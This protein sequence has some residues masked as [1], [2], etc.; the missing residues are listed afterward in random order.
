MILLKLKSFFDGH[1]MGSC[2]QYH[3]MQAAKSEFT[4]DHSVA[5]SVNHRKAKLA[6][7]MA[8]AAR[9]QKTQA[10][11]MKKQHAA[12]LNV[13]IGSIVCLKVDIRDRSRCNSTG[14]IAVAFNVS[15]N[16]GGF[17]RFVSMV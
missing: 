9:R 6:N 16:T 14:I 15:K 3:I 5:D 11:Q 1:G 12:S 2:E 10:E 4:S 13:E 8:I 7:D 17:N